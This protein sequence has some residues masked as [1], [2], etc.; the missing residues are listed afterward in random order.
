MALLKKNIWSL[1]LLILFTLLISFFLLSFKIIEYNNKDFI[2]E[3]EHLTKITSNSLTSL[4]I[5]Y[6]M[7]LDV[8]GSE[9]VESNNYTSLE[10]SRIILDR[11]LNLNSNI[12]AFGLANIDGQ[13][14]LTSS[15]LKDIKQ[16]PNLL[17]K[18]ET[19]E[20]FKESLEK[21]E[22]V[23]GRTYFHNTLQTLVIPIRK[24]IK[25]EKGE[26][27]AVMTAGINVNKSFAIIN[28]FKHHT[29]VFRNSDYFNQLTENR[30]NNITYDKPIPQEHIHCSKKV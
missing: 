13:L 3:Q 18:S 24:A 20:S 2:N 5:Q 12:D 22:M 8:L 14:Y 25:N 4:F 27:L 10:K 7:I 19:K 15:N 16:L 21:N 26:N 23:I 11:L 28:D 29:I 9:L 17:Q 1:F 30:K 6:E